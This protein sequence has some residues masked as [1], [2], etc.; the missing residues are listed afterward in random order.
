MR[1]TVMQR[2][3][4]LRLLDRAVICRLVYNQDVVPHVPLQLGD[5]HHLDKLVYIKADGDVLV[6]PKLTRF[7]QRFNEIKALFHSF[8]TNKK[9]EEENVAASKPETDR[10]P[11]ELE[12]EKS[13]GPIK[14][15]MPY[16]YLTSLQDLKRKVQAG[17]V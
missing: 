5:F 13:P 4:N 7:D 2:M 10:T 11:F 17:E 9:V 14:D 1:N 8:S 16:W 15:H 12:C 3:E 6:N